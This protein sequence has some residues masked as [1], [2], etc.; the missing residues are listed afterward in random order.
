MDKLGHQ[1]R[2]GSLF[3]HLRSCIQARASRRSLC[4]QKQDLPGNTAAHCVICWIRMSQ[5]EGVSCD[6]RLKGECWGCRYMLN[7][8]QLQSWCF[9]LWKYYNRIWFVLW[10][11]SFLC[12]AATVLYLSLL[13]KKGLYRDISSQICCFWTCRN[14]NRSDL[15]RL[16]STTCWWPWSCHKR[17]C[18]SS[19]TWTQSS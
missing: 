6:A 14:I 17:L 4:G 2:N 1:H 13:W 10:W 12:R 7:L 16:C 9:L 3:T 18:S 19:Y 11:E 15:P 8:L 5:H